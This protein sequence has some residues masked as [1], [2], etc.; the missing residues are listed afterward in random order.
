MKK[1]IMS[2][3]LTVAV[4][5]IAIVGMTLAYFTSTD[6]ATN[7][8]TFGNVNIDLIEQQRDDE[9]TALVDFEQNKPLIPI[10]GSAQGDKDDLGLPIAANYVDKVVT[11]KN[12]GANDAYIRTYFAIP[13]VLDDGAD[14]FN[15]GHNILHFNFGNK[16]VDDQVVTTYQNEWIWKNADGSWKYFETTI[17]G[18]SYNVYY[19][20]YYQAVHSGETTERFIDG[21]YLDSTVE[22]DAEGNMW[23]QGEIVNL[24]GLDLANVKCPVFSIACQSAGFESAEAAFNAAFGENYNPFAE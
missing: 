12:T 10:V 14:T 11:I 18:I 20:D 24:E 17:D 9:G 7:T 23:H 2:I 15:A 13:S 3:G 16:V 8:F 19:A 6:E 5:A 4:I 1:K 21:V 22:F